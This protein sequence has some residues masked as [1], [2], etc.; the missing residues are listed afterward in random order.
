MANDVIEKLSVKDFV[1]DTVRAPEPGYVVWFAEGVEKA[2]REARAKP[3]A[4]IS[5]DEARR[6]L[7]L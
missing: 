3:E 2:R 5:L 7:G 6:R 1:E 4:M